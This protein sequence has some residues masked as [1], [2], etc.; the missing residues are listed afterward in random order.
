MYK[1]APKV[2]DLSFQLVCYDEKYGIRLSYSQPFFCI[3][4]V[5]FRNFIA[6][7]DH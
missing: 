1:R 4:G 6:K 2:P 5:C 3:F 7:T